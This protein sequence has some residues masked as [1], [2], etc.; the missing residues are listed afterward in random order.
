MKKFQE[1]L[2]KINKTNIL[3]KK[4]FKGVSFNGKCGCSCQGNYC[5]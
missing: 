2:K 5:R 1:V 4:E 3:S